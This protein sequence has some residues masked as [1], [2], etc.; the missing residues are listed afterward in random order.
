MPIDTFN[1]K[2]QELCNK[3]LTEWILSLELCK[4]GHG[5]GDKGGV[6][7]IALFSCLWQTVLSGLGKDGGANTVCE[8]VGSGEGEEEKPPF[9]AETGISL[10]PLRM[11]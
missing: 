7:V 1:M 8:C 10:E 4:G 6:A 9:A 2:Q 3:S 5:E 11:I